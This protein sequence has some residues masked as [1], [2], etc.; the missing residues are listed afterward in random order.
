MRMLLIGFSTNV[1][2]ELML[3]LTEYLFM[4]YKRI[5]SFRVF[6]I[7]SSGFV[8]LATIANAHNMLTIEHIGRFKVSKHLFV[9]SYLIFA[10]AFVLSSF[11]VCLDIA[12]LGMV[13]ITFATIYGELTVLGYQKLIPQKLIASYM[14]GKEAAKFFGIF[15]GMSTKIGYGQK[16]FIPFFLCYLLIDPSFR[17]FQWIDTM[18]ANHRP[19]QPTIK[20]KKENVGIII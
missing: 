2:M 13:I 5:E 14:L 7:I 16:L 19:M 20:V 15:A 18:R 6:E 11:K 9:W 8:V 10:V 1:H 12:S 17:S 4:N 3:N